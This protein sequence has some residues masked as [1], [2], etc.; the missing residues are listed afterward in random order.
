MSFS[1]PPSRSIF[2]LSDMSYDFFNP[3][4]QIKIF[5]PERPFQRR[6]NFFNLRLIYSRRRRRRRR[7]R[8][9]LLLV[10]LE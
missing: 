8:R 6:L 1:P 10:H 7:R 5:P 9:L 4:R 3:R 2:S